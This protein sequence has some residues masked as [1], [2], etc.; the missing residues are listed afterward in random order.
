MDYSLEEI[1]LLLKIILEIEGNFRL[2]H[3]SK[4]FDEFFSLQNSLNS[5]GITTFTNNEGLFEK[6]LKKFEL[7]AEKFKILHN[8]EE[9][10]EIVR[11]YNGNLSELFTKFEF[12]SKELRETTVFREIK[13]KFFLENDC[14]E[15]SRKKPI[16]KLGIF[17]KE[18]ENRKI[19]EILPFYQQYEVFLKGSSNFFDL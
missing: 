7:L 8:F 9:I 17:P 16:K 4:F 13:H 1:S 11:F 6:Y 15:F 2:F 12:L 10:E 3:S 14:F 18:L 19:K 5:K